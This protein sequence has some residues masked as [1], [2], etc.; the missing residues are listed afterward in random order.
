MKPVNK[1]ALWISAA[2]LV[3][4]ACLILAFWPRRIPPKKG[5]P[6]PVVSGGLAF[7]RGKGRIAIV[8]DDW[9]Y[10]LH[11]L[12]ALKS[13]HRPITVAVLPSL[14]YSSRVARE[15]RAEGLEVIL[16]LPMEAVDPKA[17]REAGTILT[18]MPRDQVVQMVDQSLASVPF[19]AGVNNHQGSKAT[20]DRPLMELVLGRIKHRH[21]YFLDSRVTENSVCRDVA[22]S[23]KVPYARR[24]VFLDNDKSPEI[25]RIRFLD[26]AKVAA[27]EGRAVGIGHDRPNTL[28]VLQEA[29][30]ALEK[31]GYTLVSASELAQESP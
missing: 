13:I 20:A 5:V 21:L 12:P 8:L 24:D 11:Q 1:S 7:P 25:I 10:S 28:Q 23:L 27:K 17:P 9:G 15:A 4:L 2:A 22:R 26:L 29:A 6:R 3:C 16:H 30:P 18:G 31:A 14:A 19:A